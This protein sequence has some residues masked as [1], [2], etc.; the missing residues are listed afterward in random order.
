MHTGR[1]QH[2]GNGWI[3]C[4]HGHRHWGR[5]GAAGLLLVDRRGPSEPTVLL[6]HRAPWTS[7]G[8]TWGVPGGARD[9]HERAVEAALREA[10][11]ETGVMVEAV[12]VFGELE[13]DHG[14]WVY[15]TVLADLVA[16]I[17]L[18]PQNESL[19]LRWVPV[20]AVDSLP[21][22]PGFAGTWPQLRGLVAAHR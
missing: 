16:A 6:Q 20:E 14:G 12:R 19:E 10:E 18:Q 15:A 1:V 4:G 17:A 7:T 22:H 5:Y 13:D 9:S 3:R 21:L 8:D 2:D 11:E